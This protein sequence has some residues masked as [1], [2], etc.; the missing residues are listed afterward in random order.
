MNIIVLY[1]D[2]AYSSRTFMYERIELLI[3]PRKRGA[4]QR[5]PIEKNP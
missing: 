3:Q 4:K 5:M 2:P 1:D